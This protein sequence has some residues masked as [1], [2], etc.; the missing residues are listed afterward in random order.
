MSNVKK[1]RFDEDRDDAFFYKV[2]A[3]S[4]KGRTGFK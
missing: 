4:A 2:R 3:S 1:R